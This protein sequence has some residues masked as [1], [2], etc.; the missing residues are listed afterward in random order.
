MNVYRLPN[1]QFARCIVCIMHHAKHCQPDMHWV[2]CF[3]IDLIRRWHC[4]VLPPFNTLASYNQWPLGHLR[5]EVFTIVGVKVVCR[6][7]CHKVVVTPNL[8]D[9]LPLSA[10]HNHR[11]SKDDGNW[12]GHVEATRLWPLMARARHTS[13]LC[14]YDKPV[15]VFSS[16]WRK[17]ATITITDFRIS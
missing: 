16:P 6:E 2:R 3:E 15:E 12:Q 13:K 7:H 11:A 4:F 1:K 9:E 5:I 10:L 14:I 8:A 17:L